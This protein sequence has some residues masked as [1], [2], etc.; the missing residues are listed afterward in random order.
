M[1]LLPANHYLRRP[2]GRGGE[3]RVSRARELCGR[4]GQVVRSG[5]GEMVSNSVGRSVPRRVP[6]LL[7]TPQSRQKSS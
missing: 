5:L 6:I 3:S 7:L 2:A 4:Q 1:W